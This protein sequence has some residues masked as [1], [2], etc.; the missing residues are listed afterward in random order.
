MT[1]AVD[2]VQRG[3][4]AKWTGENKIRKKRFL[5][6]DL[7]FVSQGPVAPSTRHQL[8]DMAVW[9]GSDFSVIF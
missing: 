2:N 1:S 9:E 6:Q 5:K 4:T 8:K 3:K 7:F